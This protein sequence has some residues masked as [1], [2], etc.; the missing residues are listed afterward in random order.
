M[1][2]F[3]RAGGRCQTAA[4]RLAGP[5][6]AATLPAVPAAPPPPAAGPPGFDPAAVF[7][8]GYR[9]AGPVEPVG[10]GFS[11]AG[12]WRVPTAAG[13]FALRL[14]P[15]DRP[16]TARLLGLH[17]LLEHAAAVDPGLPL[18]VPVC[19]TAGATLFPLGGR[20]AQLEPWRP[21]EP[22]AV[23]PDPADLAAAVGAVARFHAAAATFVPP[24]AA[25]PYFAAGPG[26]VSPS[27]T[28][29][30]EALANWDDRARRDAADGAR[31]SPD[32]PFRDAAADLLA[33]VDRLGPALADR[34]AAA[35]RVVVPLSPVLRDVHREHVL[36][37]DGTVTGLID[38]SA[39]LADSPAADLA[40]LAVSLT[41]GLLPELIAG[42]RAVR[43][44][45]EAEADLA[46]VLHDSGTLLSGL[47]WVGRGL[48]SD[49]SPAAR[50]RLA[51][52]AAAVRA[53]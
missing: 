8:P 51:H 12:M 42:Y 49:L 30:R 48:R 25:R 1:G 22:L 13:T 6:P 2:R 31:R 16:P 14:W 41:P 47:V 44:L 50:D 11:G 5:P 36:M 46:A 7:G 38:P 39:A 35:A 3:Y 19:T 10:G 17:A 53:L 34:L 33:A 23:D 37:T 4:G 15:R 32:P 9:L 45:S 52:F 21:G 29:R 28:G 24:A 20:R 40:R 27:L 26:A 18:A 43:E